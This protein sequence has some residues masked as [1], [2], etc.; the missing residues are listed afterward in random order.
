MA[1]SSSAACT[2]R[3]WPRGP[4]CG[5]PLTRSRAMRRRPSA[6]CS[7]RRSRSGAPSSGVR[8]RIVA[9]IEEAVVS[10][11]ASTAAITALIGTGANMRM[12][13]LIV[14]QTA[15]LPA[16]AY[17]KVSSPKE[18]AHPGSTHLCRSRFQFT[19]EADTYSSVKALA[20]AVKDCW[21]SFRGTVNTVRIDGCAIDNDVDS[22]LERQAAVSPVVRIDVLIWHYE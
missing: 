17:Q 9:T 13:P 18:Q 20:T 16:V 14:P 2:I 10:K 4:G 7:T 5:R 22:A 21:N 3:A 19:C 11:M 15:A 6:P 1:W 8:L 12:Y